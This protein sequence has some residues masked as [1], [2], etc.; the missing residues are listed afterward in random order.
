M[1]PKLYEKG[2][3]TKILEYVNDELVHFEQIFEAIKQE[4]F[5]HELQKL[6]DRFLS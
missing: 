4:S 6:R 3:Y 5:Y 1:I 2:E